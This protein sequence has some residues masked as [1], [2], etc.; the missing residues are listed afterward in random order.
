[1]VTVCHHQVL[2]QSV[3]DYVIELTESLDV[4]F[5]LTLGLS[6]RAQPGPSLSG[7]GC[8]S[9]APMH[10]SLALVYNTMGL[11]KSGYANQGTAVS[12]SFKASN[13]RW[14]SSVHLNREY[15]FVRDIRGPANR[16]NVGMNLL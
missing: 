5:S 7:E 3:T 13:A 1:M 11:L 12:W 15:F 6:Q 2:F 9:T 4:S 8:V 16:L 10:L 14:Q